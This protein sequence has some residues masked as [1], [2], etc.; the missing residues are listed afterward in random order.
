MA[1]IRKTVLVSAVIATAFASRPAAAIT[2]TGDALADFSGP[3]VA[4]FTDPVGDVG[5]PFNAPAMTISGWDYQAV[6]FLLDENTDMLHVGIDFYGIGGDVDGNGVDGVSASWLLTNNGHDYAGMDHGESVVVAFDFDQ[7]GSFDLLA[8]VNGF[9]TLYNVALHNGIPSLPYGFGASMPGFDGG[10]FWDPVNTPGDYE[11]S[12]ANFSMLDMPVGDELCFD[13][14]VFAGSIDDDGVG[15]DF[16]SFEICLSSRS[17]ATE[18]LPV[19]FAVGNY[20]NPFNP[21]TTIAFSLPATE[22]TELAVFNLAGHK[23]ATL[24]DGIL[25]AGSHDVV[26]DASGLASGL[27]VYTL[28][29][30]NLVQS[31]RMMLTK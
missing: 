7:N 5:M 18:E 3:G 9:N 29:S 19:S 2:F 10:H 27:Y 21:T 6:A 8:G 16:D 26:F 24:V 4:V 31:G 25:A 15:E 11:L 30:G 14:M 22:M 23:V 12:I 17:G 13:V 1:L 20:P 28:R